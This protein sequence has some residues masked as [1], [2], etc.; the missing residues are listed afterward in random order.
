MSAIFKLECKKA[1]ANR[2][3][4]FVLILFTGFL[5]TFVFLNMRTFADAR[6]REARIFQQMVLRVETEAKIAWDRTAYNPRHVLPR[7]L[8]EEMF[9][10]HVRGA[11]NR[12]HTLR[13]LAEYGRQMAVA[14]TDNDRETEQ[15]MINN[16]YKAVIEHH[17]YQIAICLWGDGRPR[18]SRIITRIGEMG[19]DYP[20]W[21]EYY[22]AKQRFSQYFVDNDILFLY[23]SEMRGFN[24]TYQV[25]RQ[26]FP[27]VMLFVVFVAVGDVFTSDNRTGSYKFLLVNPVPRWKVFIAKWLASCAIAMA[28][29]FTPL[30][31]M[32]L[33]VGI[34]NGF[35]PWNYPILTQAGAFSSFT[36]IPNNIWF[37]QLT[38]HFTGFFVYFF[39]LPAHFTN[40]GLAYAAAH[41]SMGLTAYSSPH[42]G[43][44]YLFSH[45]HTLQHTPM[46]AVLAMA[47]PIFLLLIVL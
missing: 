47:L 39:D 34:V 24:F 3:N 42:M 14:I 5:L 40:N 6:E 28:I 13:Q 7:G 37:D 22:L 35:G 15:A 38:G 30:V 23:E 26:I 25:M 11:T 33:G 43:Y 45:H 20:R 44:L 41:P 16:M 17:T 10:N 18:G 12:Y 36:P 2:K 19:V 1:L 21:R 27:L 29:I 8:P 32:G 31:L 9:I 46:V 4:W